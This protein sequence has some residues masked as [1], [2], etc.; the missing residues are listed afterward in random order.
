MTGGSQQLRRFRRAIR[1]GDTLEEAALA[2]GISLGEAR[3]HFEADQRDPPPPEAFELINTA[4]AVGAN[5]EEGS[6]AKKAKPGDA[7]GGGVTNLTETKDVV[8]TAV[9]EIIRLRNQR[10]ELNAAMGEQRARVKN[11]GV[12]P[13]ALDLA[14]RMKEADAE[15]RQKHD[16]GYAIARDALGLGL[17]LQRS[18]FEALDE[19]LDAEAKAPP[20][21]AN[22]ALDRSRGHLG[23]ASPDAI[24]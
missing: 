7:A 10:K 24:N 16:E 4:P 12:P 21:G 22:A 5:V 1:N 17:G 8:R 20:P 3:M 18:L 14:I 19:R 13:A 11:Y 9:A 6:M 23:G 15:D 2:A